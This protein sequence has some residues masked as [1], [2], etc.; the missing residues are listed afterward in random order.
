[1]AT[2]EPQDRHH[3]P[4]LHHRETNGEAHH[5]HHPHFHHADSNGSVHHHHHK[6]L[7]E[8]ADP[9]QVINDRDSVASSRSDLSQ[10]EAD[11]TTHDDD[12]DE[13][14][15]NGANDDTSPVN[16][17]KS[18]ATTVELNG[19]EAAR[20][21]ASARTSIAYNIALKC[22]HPD[23][24]T[25]AHTLPPS[26]LP[27][28]WVPGAM[29]HIERATSTAFGQI[30]SPRNSS[31]GDRPKPAPAVHKKVV[32]QHLLPRLTFENPWRRRFANQGSKIW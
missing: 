14:D 11:E 9:Q 1:M 6:T 17:N 26:E 25:D 20:R 24:I 18:G 7:S 22:L 13:A 8:R 5:H 29:S 15:D 27:S 30:V 28:H 12:H 10:E 23:P 19:S 31:S 4:H 3:H 16:A 32:E 21:G 2:T